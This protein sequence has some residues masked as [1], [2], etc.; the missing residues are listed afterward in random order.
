[1]LQK[2]D[3]I[4][5]QAAVELGRRDE[6]R[7][8]ETAPF[9]PPPGPGRIHRDPAGQTHDEYRQATPRGGHQ[10][11]EGGLIPVDPVAQ[12]GVQL[13]VIVVAGFPDEAHVANAY[14]SLIEGERR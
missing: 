3:A 5:T 6:L 8:L 9:L 10:E 12:E 7:P 1:M 4:G 14:A 2:A 11:V 13:R